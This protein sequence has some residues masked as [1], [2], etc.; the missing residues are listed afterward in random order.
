LNVQKHNCRIAPA[1]RRR[2]LGAARAEGVTCA[3]KRSM[4]DVLTHLMVSFFNHENVVP[5]AILAIVAV[6]AASFVT[7]LTI[8]LIARGFDFKRTGRHAAIEVRAPSQ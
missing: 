5:S 8:C 3:H 2:K 1:N 6:T 7:I 4:Q